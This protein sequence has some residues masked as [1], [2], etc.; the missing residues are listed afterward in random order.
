MALKATYLSS[1]SV[2]ASAAVLFGNELILLRLNKGISLRRLARAVGMTAH[3]GLVDYERGLR[4]RDQSLSNPCPE[5]IM[6]IGRGRIF[7]VTPGRSGS[8]HRSGTGW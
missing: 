7:G 4:H 5:G 3:S 8:S 1:T 2:N 6:S